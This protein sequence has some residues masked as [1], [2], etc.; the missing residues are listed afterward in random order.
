MTED[1]GAIAALNDEFRSTFIGGQV[2]L[3]RGIAALPEALRLEILQS[4][5]DFTAFDAGDDPY[6]E[7]DF[8]AIECRGRSVFW[9]IDY[10]SPDLTSA[11]ENPADIAAT[12][13]VL[14]VMLA[15]EY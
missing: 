5:R 1:S 15:E 9:K 4:V 7:H 8:G 2:V 14:T 13:R 6:G 11:S 3:T 12:T 10:Y